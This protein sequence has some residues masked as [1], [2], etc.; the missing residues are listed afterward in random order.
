MS[1]TA[2][3]AALAMPAARPRLALWPL[4][5][6]LT[7]ATYGTMPAVHAGVF[8]PERIRAAAV[9]EVRERLGADVS[10]GMRERI[11][12]N[13]TASPPWMTGAV[14]FFTTLLGVAVAGVLLNAATLLAGADVAS[15]DTFGVAAAA[16][17]AVAATRVV[18]WAACL[19]SRGVNGVTG[20]DW[21]APGRISLADVAGAPAGSQAGY[22]LAS[23][24]LTL[25][26]GALVATV[27]LRAADRR[28][29]LPAAAAT[30]L[31]WPAAVIGVHVALS[32]ALGFNVS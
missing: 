28:L 9:Q 16:A 15:G 5:L 25:L 23:V 2:A 27:G 14:A 6:L 17:L 22:A 12:Q 1:V 8:G 10:D 20:V 26:V 18:L 13:L 4:L 19:A 29:G 24:D 3:P 11:A 30:A 7:A 32:A 31:V 21:L